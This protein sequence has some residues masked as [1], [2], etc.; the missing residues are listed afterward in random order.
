M[1]WLSSLLRAYAD[2]SDYRELWSIS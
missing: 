1:L 2:K